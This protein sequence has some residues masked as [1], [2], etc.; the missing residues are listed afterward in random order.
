MLFAVR[1]DLVVFSTNCW[2]YIPIFHSFFFV[3]VQFA[4][5]AE[6]CALAVAIACGRADAAPP[7][8][9]RSPALL[10][11]VRELAAAEPLP[12]A[13]PRVDDAHQK[14]NIT[15]DIRK[16]PYKRKTAQSTPIPKTGPPQ[17]ANLSLFY[18][19]TYKKSFPSPPTTASVNN[20]AARYKR[21][22]YGVEAAQSTT[23]KAVF[24]VE[25]VV[26]TIKTDIVY[27]SL[28]NN[29]SIMYIVRAKR[30]LDK[31]EFKDELSSARAGL[32][33]AAAG[34][35]PA[36]RG[37][38]LS[39]LDLDEP[40]PPASLVENAYDELLDAVQRYEDGANI[41]ISRKTFHLYERLERAPSRWR[42]IAIVETATTVS[43][44]TGDWTTSAEISNS[45]RALDSW[46]E[47]SAESE[48]AG[49][50]V[51][52]P[53]LVACL[54]LALSAAGALAL[55]TRWA[56]RR[57]RRRRR[58]GDAVLAAGEFAFPADERRRVGEGMETMLSC[59]LQQLH[60]F[61]GPELERPDL[62]KQP[63]RAAPPAPPA[64]LAPLAPAA[65]SAPSSTCSINRVA[66]DRRTRYKVCIKYLE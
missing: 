53:V 32:D 22:R 39:A 33:A 51:S 16:S 48:V 3:E 30:A 14:S 36:R 11:H 41:E 19:G 31:N 66:L 17:N 55:G 25:R 10:L 52:V 20:V 45:S 28:R 59:W 27:D 62:L 54:A 24:Q 8:G 65:P 47:E 43:S 34:P 42:R 9:A 6:C 15:L 35:G 40:A 23:S 64:P 37:L 58:R 5:K 2:F 50:A 44:E 4:F 61:G 46:S 21:T 29:S 38:L 18:P 1:M 26:N 63:P 49:S 7:A 56:A 57:R 13:I 60:E 12:T